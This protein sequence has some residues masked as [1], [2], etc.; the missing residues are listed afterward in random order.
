MADEEGE[1]GEEGERP[2][3]PAAVGRRKA[4]AEQEQSEGDMY[5]LVGPARDDVDH[6]VYSGTI[7]R[8]SVTV[9]Y[10]E[11]PGELAEGGT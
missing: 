11:T 2:K 8:L 6:E 5:A 7:D 3:G 1:E 4:E 10:G 9:R